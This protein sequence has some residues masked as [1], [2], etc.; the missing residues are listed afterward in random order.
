MSIKF[1]NKTSISGLRKKRKRR[2]RRRTIEVN[3]HIRIIFHIVFLS[4]WESSQ[5]IVYEYYEKFI[6]HI[7]WEIIVPLRFFF[8]ST[9]Y[10]I[11]KNSINSM[12]RIFILKNKWF[13]SYSKK[14]I[15]LSKFI[16]D[17][18]SNNWVEIIYLSMLIIYELLEWWIT[19]II[20]WE[21]D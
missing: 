16:N 6:F 13:V 21:R 5:S 18:S 9:T 2:R 12:R 1:L 15:K 3:G 8:A 7:L 20:W 10:T 11:Y 4:I 19:E 17:G 14:L